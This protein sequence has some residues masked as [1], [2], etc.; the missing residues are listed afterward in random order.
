[1]RPLSSQI[2]TE[3]KPGRSQADCAVA[4]ANMGMASKVTRHSLPQQALIEV[5][6]FFLGTKLN[7]LMGFL[8]L[9]VISKAAGWGDGATCALSMIALIPMAEVR[10]KV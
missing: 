7:I 6:A 2:E 4:A 9:A 1:M 8:I 3:E 10:H 5:K